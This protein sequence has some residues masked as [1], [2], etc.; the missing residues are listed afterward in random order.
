MYEKD[1]NIK[2]ERVPRLRGFK[3]SVLPNSTVVARCSRSEK[4]STILSFLNDNQD[5]LDRGL[6]HSRE[7]QTKYPMLT[8]QEGEKLRFLG[9][10]YALKYEKLDKKLIK[11]VEIKIERP[12]FVIK[13]PAN[14]WCENF[15]HFAHPN[16]RKEILRFYEKT[17][18]RF[19]PK[20][21]DDLAK[22]TGLVPKKVI[23]RKQK[24]V[25][26]SCSPSGNIQLN[27][28][29]ISAPINVIDYVII[30]EL[31][32][33]KHPNH[34]LDF[35]SEVERFCPDYKQLRLWLKRHY[36]SFD[37]LNETSELHSS[38]LKSELR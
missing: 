15:S 38:K 25:W 36:F 37:Y 28:K 8:F 14:Q 21:V 33:L 2:L 13:V 6:K 4:L 9:E 5:W 1:R 7:L 30:H 17:A 22:Q 23:L 11:K 10:N 32:H 31:A 3:V 26:G 12:Y 24:T 16:F 20:R 34:S 29:L 19:L 27:W 18:M 35:W